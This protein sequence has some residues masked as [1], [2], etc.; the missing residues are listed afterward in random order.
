MG[1]VTTLMAVAGGSGYGAITTGGQAYSGQ[2]GSQ[3]QPAA[4]AQVR[5]QFSS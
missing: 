5:Q 4:G 2:G 3:Q 1:D